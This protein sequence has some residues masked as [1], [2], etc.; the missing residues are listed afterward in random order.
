[1]ILFSHSKVYSLARPGF[2]WLLLFL[3]FLL[4]LLYYNEN[5]PTSL[6]VRGLGFFFIENKSNDLSQIFSSLV[7]VWEQNKTSPPEKDHVT[8]KIPVGM[9]IQNYFH[10]V[11]VQNN[12][13]IRVKNFSPK[14]FSQRDYS[15]KLRHFMTI[16]NSETTVVVDKFLKWKSGRYKM[17]KRTIQCGTITR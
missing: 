3:L 9:L 6:E 15:N 5:W 4:L 1:M 14:F 7:N 2:H 13:L 16:F 17:G 12:I 10:D 11:L 8:F